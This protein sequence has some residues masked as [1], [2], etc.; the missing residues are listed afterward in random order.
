MPLIPAP[1][2]SLAQ[3][4]WTPRITIWRDDGTTQ[5]REGEPCESWAARWRQAGA[6]RPAPVLWMAD[7]QL[8]RR[9]HRAE[10]APISIYRPGIRSLAWLK[11]KPRVTL[12][13]VVMGGSSEPIQWGDWGLAVMLE[14]AYKQPPDGKPRSDTPSRPHSA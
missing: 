11:V 7:T 14:I 5:R 10:G 3:A 1:S 12:E 2:Y 6:S 9:G 4:A 13:I 8:G